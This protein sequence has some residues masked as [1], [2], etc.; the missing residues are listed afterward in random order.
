MF[1]DEGNTRKYKEETTMNKQDFNQAVKLSEAKLKPWGRHLLLLKDG[2]YKKVT[3]ITFLGNVTAESLVSRIN[4]FESESDHLT[5]WLNEFNQ[6]DL[7]KLPN[8]KFLLCKTEE[9]LRPFI[10]PHD[11]FVEWGLKPSIFEVIKEEFDDMDFFAKSGTFTVDEDDQL[12]L[13]GKIVYDLEIYNAY[14]FYYF[15][16]NDVLLDDFMC[17]GIHEFQLDK[18]LVAVAYTEKTDFYE[19]PY[20]TS[21]EERRLLGL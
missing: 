9:G 19:V 8:G 1:I 17:E 2:I 5:W 18:D 15:L 7:I 10:I 14:E 20:C 13:N 4:D 11:T 6:N 21:F 3:D 16:K 12:Y